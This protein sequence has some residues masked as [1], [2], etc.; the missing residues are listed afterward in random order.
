MMKNN[1]NIFKQASWSIVSRISTAL[2]SFIS[3]SILLKILGVGQFGIW[4]TISGLFAAFSFVDLGLANGLRNKL[5]KFNC[6]NFYSYYSNCYNCCY[7]LSSTWW[8]CY[9]DWFFKIR[10]KH[11]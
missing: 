6:S 10:R 8:F 7:N 3:I 9:F 11:S 1:Y 5:Q 2:F 4:I